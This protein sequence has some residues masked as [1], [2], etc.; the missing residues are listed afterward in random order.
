[1]KKPKQ[2]L[3][4]ILSYFSDK[5]D[6]AEGFLS[7]SKYKYISQRGD[8]DCATACIKMATKGK[9]NEPHKT[10]SLKQ[11]KEVLNKL[12]LIER[13]EYYVSKERKSLKKRDL[14]E[15]KEGILLIR[16]KGKDYGHYIFINELGEIFDPE[17]GINKTLEKYERKNNFVIAKIKLKTLEG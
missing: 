1:M 2:W 12:N 10:G 15:N 3:E 9:Y 11:L 16:E 5:L 13:F 17:E 8:N 7:K 14:L 4:N 6:T